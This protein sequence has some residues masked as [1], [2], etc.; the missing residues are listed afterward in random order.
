[1]LKEKIEK[2]RERLQAD[3]NKLNSTEEEMLTFLEIL[4]T[5]PSSTVINFDYKGNLQL[6]L[7]FP[8]S[9]D[10]L[11]DVRKSLGDKWKFKSVS[12]H[13][14]FIYRTYVSEEYSFKL[15]LDLDSTYEGSTC[16][17]VQVGTREIPVYEVVCEK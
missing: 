12:E 6:H 16:Q 1:M 3:L 9:L 7:I 2:E 14:W 4:G 11:K 5:E 10:L 8:Y 15:L 17:M 13:G